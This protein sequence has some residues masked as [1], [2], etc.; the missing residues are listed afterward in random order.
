MTVFPLN[1]Q[2]RKIGDF[3]MQNYIN[4]KN[5]QINSFIE[6][7]DKE[8][9]LTP[10]QLRESHEKFGN[11]RL[12]PPER[13]PAWK[14][15]LENY[16]EPT[17]ILLLIAAAISIG[18]GIQTEE[19]IEGVGIIAAIIL[20][21]TISFVSEYE[22]KK[23]FEKL[24]EK[25]PEYAKVTREGKIM[26]LPVDELVIGD[27]VEL[28]QGNRIPADGKLIHAQ[29]LSADESLLTGEA[30]PVG[31]GVDVDQKE[32]TYPKNVV[33]RGTLVNDGIGKF[34][35]TRIGDET[36]M[37]KISANLGQQKEVSTPLQE[38][39][40]K[41]AK[42]IGYVGGAAAFLI[43]SALLLRGVFIDETI[44]ALTPQ[45]IEELLTYFMI[46]VTIIVVAIP[47]GLPVMVS[48]SLA[49][50]MRKMARENAL[51]KKMIASETVGAVTVICSDK[52][53]TLTRNRMEVE[54][55]FINNSEYDKDHL[56]N[57]PAS[58]NWKDLLVNSA[59]N[60]T[61]DIEETPENEIRI[62]G[63][64]TEGALL[65]L[66][67]NSGV[68]Y[69]DIR[70][71]AEIAYQVPFS[72]EAKFMATAV[73]E[74]NGYRVYLKGAPGVI[75]EKCS[76]VM[77]DGK[78]QP[79]DTYRNTLTEMEKK[80]SD[81]SYRVL[82]FAQ[83]KEL[84]NSCNSEE[85]CLSADYTFVALTGIADPLREGVREA[86]ESAHKAGI[87]V[88]MI[89]GDALN[90]AVAIA[91]NSGI[92]RSR[93]DIAIS[94]KDFIS[95]TDEELDH[96]VD[97]IKVLSRIQPLDKLRL[98]ESLHR[99]GETVGV[100][101]DGTN[102]APALKKSDVGIAM[103]I[104]GT[105][106]SKE[107]ADLILL[108]DNFK[109]IVTGIRWGRTIYE[110]IQRLIQFQLTV[111]VV[112][113]LV[114]FSGPFI[115]VPLPLTI[116]QLLWINIFMDSLGAVALA[117]EPPR[118]EVMGDRPRRRNE[119]IVTG[120][121]IGFI[122]L[123]GLYMTIV[124]FILVATNFLGGDTTDEH[125]SSVFNMFVF[126]QIWNIF[127]ARA[128]RYGES[129]FK[130]LNKNKTLLAIVAGVILIQLIV[131]NYGG[132]IF[133][134]VPLSPDIWFWTIIITATI[135]PYGYFAKWLIRKHIQA[136]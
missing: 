75:L 27:I 116:I 57:L 80:A 125:L 96:K 13:K 109:T 44:T 99:K 113:L 49:L 79:I 88:K 3:G 55:A 56:E 86:V 103:G 33:L 12:T 108:D 74:E 41:L 111:N 11:N 39:L 121:M 136:K 21:T 67:L 135:I 5:E 16:K 118:S 15:Y 65:K 90:T 35:V 69:K 64:T 58:E 24:S 100:T 18:V 59:A 52:T 53:G 29:R 4:N 45:A 26:S 81:Q 130:N 30:E 106:V 48:L 10:E 124:L 76:F 38:R 104:A 46:A 6:K 114:A 28:E 37:G 47:E 54:W 17:I 9:G 117:S 101:G 128:L 72:S 50:N 36:E 83:S 84:L 31:K 127:N 62:L 134:T 97:Q 23:A 131:V 43:F 66:M 112:A 32:R 77:T 119:S 129:P 94:R 40:H 105:D 123:T 98:V 25:S 60:S 14:I 115:G 133:R 34:I 92:L 107:A 63:D 61:A 22:S 122:G 7:V 102:D 71:S 51:V 68:N 20:A 1:L 42:Q 132:E 120:N 85:E 91:K 93:E 8:Q 95:L 89:T 82:A 110:N 78:N 73:R 70:N 19:Y 2:E 87:D 126:F